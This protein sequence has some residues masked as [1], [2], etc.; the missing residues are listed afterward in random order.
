MNLFE[1]KWTET[2]DPRWIAILNEAAGLLARSKVYAAGNQYLMCR[3]TSSFQRPGV[4]VDH[5]AE[6]FAA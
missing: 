1:V 3:T 2:A 5:P 6:F 4:H